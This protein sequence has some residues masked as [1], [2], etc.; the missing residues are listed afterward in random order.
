MKAVVTDK[1]IRCTEY[2]E[3]PGCQTLRRR[4]E[5]ECFCL[6]FCNYCQ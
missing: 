1:W 4:A 3:G 6:R 2:M 5:T